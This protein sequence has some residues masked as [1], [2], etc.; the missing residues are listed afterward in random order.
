MLAVA[1]SIP[2]RLD[3]CSDSVWYYICFNAEYLQYRGI[4]HDSQTVPWM[5]PWSRR[6]C[7]RAVQ[8]FKWC[9]KFS[10]LHRKKMES[11]GFDFFVGDVISG[12]G[13][14]PF[15]LRLPGS[16]I[17]PLNR[18]LWKFLLETWLES[19]SFEP[20]IDFLAFLAMLWSWYSNFR[21]RLQFQASKILA[22]TPA[23]TFASFGL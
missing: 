15:W 18:S 8:T 4:C 14:R 12:I 10:G 17:Q 1:Y 16:G 21:L 11:F 5:H 6:L 7:K 19:K 9:S 2:P 13:F 23:R 22:L 3:T 20:L